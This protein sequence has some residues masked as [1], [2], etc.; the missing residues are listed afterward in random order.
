MLPFV[1]DADRMT[2]PLLALLDATQGEL[3]VLGALKAAPFELAI[4]LV[5]GVG[6]ETDWTL[7]D[8]ATDVRAPTPTGAAEMVVT[9]KPMKSRSFEGFQSQ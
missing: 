8:L 3:T 4:P 7:I 5:S 9:G 6:H 1:P 2:A